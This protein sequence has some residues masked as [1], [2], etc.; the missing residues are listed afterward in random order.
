MRTKQSTTVLNSISLYQL[1]SR[2]QDGIRYVRDLL[3]LRRIKGEEQE[4]AGRL[5][6][7]S[8]TPEKGESKGG[9][10]VRE[11][12]RLQGQRGLS[13]SDGSLSKV[14]LQGWICT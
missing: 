7:L 13:Q 11:N 1:R 8:L 12:F 4:Q 9:Q 5:V 6:M 14:V 2:P 3:G 10:E